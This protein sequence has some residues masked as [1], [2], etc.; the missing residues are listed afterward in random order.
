MRIQMKLLAACAAIVA[1]PAIAQV[2]VGTDTGVGVGVNVPV[3]HTIHTVDRTVDTVDRNVNR[4][5]DTR[6]TVATRADVSGG[7][8]VRDS[9]G[10][11]IGIVQ[12]VSADS[13]VVVSGR[14]RVRVPISSLYRSANGLVTRMSRDQFS[15]QARAQARGEA[16]AD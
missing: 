1:V 15:A 8:T 16:R 7:A 10:R 4:G 12:S 3:D 5:V 9:R 2:S 14:Q 13:A 11:R 6:L